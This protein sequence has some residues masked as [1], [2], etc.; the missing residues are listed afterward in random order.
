MRLQCVDITPS[1]STSRSAFQNTALG[2]LQIETVPGSDASV[3]YSP[4]IEV[5][6]ATLASSSAAVGRPSDPSGSV[7]VPSPVPSPIVWASTVSSSPLIIIP[8]PAPHAPS[9]TTT[10]QPSTL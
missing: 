7:P 6:V 1:Q 8:V 9:A 10:V 3:E 5:H 2:K 4:P